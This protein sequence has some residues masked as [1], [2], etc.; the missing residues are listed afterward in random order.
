MRS[1]PIKKLSTDFV[2]FKAAF[3]GCEHQ[4]AQKRY[5]ADLTRWMHLVPL[6]E[7]EPEEHER[8]VSKRIIEEWMRRPFVGRP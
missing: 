7:A 5:E 1:A 4:E 6:P 2:P 3:C 8:P